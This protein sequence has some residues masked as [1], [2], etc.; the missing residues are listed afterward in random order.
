M[1]EP[2]DFRNEAG[3]HGS[4]LSMSFSRYKGQDDVATVS[5]YVIT[6]TNNIPLDIHVPIKEV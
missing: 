1:A 2:T 4:R 6:Y 3:N 5:L